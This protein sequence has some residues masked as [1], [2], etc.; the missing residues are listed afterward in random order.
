MAKS[1]F[2]GR[3]VYEGQH[4]K[5]VKKRDYNPTLHST[6]FHNIVLYIFMLHI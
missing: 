4:L 1:G 2:G 5:A 6:G 3:L